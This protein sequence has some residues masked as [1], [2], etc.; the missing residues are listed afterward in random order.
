MLYV[1]LANGAVITEYSCPQDAAD[2]PGYSEIAED[3]PEAVAWKSSQNV[4]STNAPI[5]AQLDALDAK[6]I[7]ALREGD[8]ARVAALEAQAAALRAQLVQ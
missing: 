2:K 7:R 1:Q 3:S 5:Q 8:A 6:S 4:A